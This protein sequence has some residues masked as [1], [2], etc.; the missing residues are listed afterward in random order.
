MLRARPYSLSAISPRTS[1]DVA[2]HIDWKS[3][4][5]SLIDHLLIHSRAQTSGYGASASPPQVARTISQ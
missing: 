2:A 5:G 3:G 4:K 1:A